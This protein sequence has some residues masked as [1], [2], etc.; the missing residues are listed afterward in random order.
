MLVK[1]RQRFRVLDEIELV[2][3]QHSLGRERESE[4]E[5]YFVEETA[6]M[7]VDSDGRLATWWWRSAAVVWLAGL[8]F[9]WS[10]LANHPF[11]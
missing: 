10:A 7:V 4:R 11:I 6:T 8:G 5:I 3:G 1:I 9:A 2:N